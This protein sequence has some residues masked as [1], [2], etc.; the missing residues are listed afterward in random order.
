[1]WDAEKASADLTPK[2]QTWGSQ[3]I[4]QASIRLKAAIVSCR[5]TRFLIVVPIPF[6]CTIKWTC[7]HVF[8]RVPEEACRYSGRPAGVSTYGPERSKLPRYSELRSAECVPHPAAREYRNAGG[9]T[10]VLGRI[11]GFSIKPLK[12]SGPCRAAR[13]SRV[14]PDLLLLELIPCRPCIIGF[15]LRCHDCLVDGRVFRAALLR[16]FDE[17]VSLALPGRNPTIVTIYELAQALGVSHL[18]LVGPEDED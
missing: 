4:L 14:R 10:T 2:R 13:A 11:S 8:H 5:S 18:G 6:L 7:N 1:M 15:A 12:S 9:S 3:F 17:C 16:R